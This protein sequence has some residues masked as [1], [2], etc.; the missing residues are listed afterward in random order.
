MPFDVKNLNVVGIVESPN[1]KY[2]LSSDRIVS[3]RKFFTMGPFVLRYL[4]A[5]CSKKLQTW[6]HHINPR[7]N[8]LHFA[9]IWSFCWPGLSLARNNF[10][11]HASKNC[12]MTGFSSNLYVGKIYACLKEIVLVEKT[13]LCK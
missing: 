9:N 1:I 13:L 7:Q 12:I 2:F 8:A 10:V 6:C 4:C 3:Q 11:V 5:I